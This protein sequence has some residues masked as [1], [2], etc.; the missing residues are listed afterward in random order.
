MEHAQ[1]VR[2]E[3]TPRLKDLG[4]LV[5]A[6]PVAIAKGQNDTVLLGEERARRAYPYRTLLKEG[7]YLSFGSDAPAEMTV[8]PRRIRD[9]TVEMTI[10]G[11]KIVYDNR[12]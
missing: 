12:N 9:V 1:L 6:Q 4:I 3:D 2:P 11:G 7:V 8:D 10:V 5:S